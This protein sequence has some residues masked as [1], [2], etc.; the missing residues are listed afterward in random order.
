MFHYALLYMMEACSASPSLSTPGF[1][2]GS[3]VSGTGVTG[4]LNRCEACD[5]ANATLI[6]VLGK[7]SVSS[8]S[9]IK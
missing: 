9:Y 6:V 7:L 5:T 3:C 1:L 4:L 8:I 2:C